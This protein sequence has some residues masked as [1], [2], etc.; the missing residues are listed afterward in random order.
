MAGRISKE[1]VICHPP[2]LG[3][4]A[5]Y[6]NTTKIRGLL[7]KKSIKAYLEAHFG[8]VPSISTLFPPVKEYSKCRNGSLSLYVSKQSERNPKR[9][10]E[11]KLI[12]LRKASG[13]R[14][15]K[16]EAVQSRGRSL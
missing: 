9:V 10:I 16:K 7:Q 15:K 6:Y 2:F 12:F 13:S 1:S 5:L 3:L 4:V 14:P 8:G 11:P